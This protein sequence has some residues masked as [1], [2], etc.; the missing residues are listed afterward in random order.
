MHV[1]RSTH[2]VSPQ[3]LLTYRSSAQLAGSPLSFTRR[4]SLRAVSPFARECHPSMQGVPTVPTMRSSKTVLRFKSVGVLEIWSLCSSWGKCSCCPATNI[5]EGQT[6]MCISS[7][8][9]CCCQALQRFACTRA[10]GEPKQA[11]DVGG[12]KQN[13]Q[14]CQDAHIPHLQCRTSAETAWSR[15]HGR[16]GTASASIRL[17]ASIWVSKGHVAVMR[18]N[19]MVKDLPC[20]QVPH[21]MIAGGKH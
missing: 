2:V 16:C 15:V 8:P 7:N 1:L 5:H 19:C 13:I 14:K 3:T 9:I 10:A 12:Y 11:S 4:T 6:D 18:T 20:N 21:L 17:S